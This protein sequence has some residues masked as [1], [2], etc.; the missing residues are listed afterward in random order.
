MENETLIVQ[1]PPAAN[2]AEQR[3]NPLQPPSSTTDDG[4]VT[5]EFRTAEELVAKAIAPVKR[6]YL[7]PPPSRSSNY[8]NTVGVENDDVAEAKSAPIIKDKKS[9]RQMKR[10][11]RQELKSPLHIC[12][13]VAKSGK[14]SACPYNDKCRFSHDVEAFK[15]EKPADI[16]GSCPFLI[17]EGPCPYGLACRFAGTHRDDVSA[18]TENLPVKSSE[19]NF[20]NKDTQ[21]LLWKNK[22]KFPETEATLKLLGLKGNPKD[23]TLGGKGE[24]GQVVPKEPATDTKTDNNEVANDSIIPFISPEDDADE[25]NLADDTRPL[26]K[27]KSSVNEI[28]SSQV[29]SGSSVQEGIL[30]SSCDVNKLEP[31]ADTVTDS[32]KSLKLHPRE[33]KLI[34][35]RD[36]LYLAPLTTVGNLPFR[37]VCKVL[38]ADVT[39]GEMAMCTN[40]LQ[41]Q[42]SEWALL[43]RHSSE[44]LFGV[45]IC[46]AY[47]DTVTKT[48]ELI[49]QECSVDFIDINMGCPIDIVVNKGAGSALLTK[50]MR[51]KSVVEAASLTVGTPVTIKVRTA[52]F[53]GKNRI[54]SLIADMGNWGATAVTIH[55][56]SRQQRYSKLADWDYIY[57]CVCKAPKSLQVLGNGDVFSY[58]DWN[59]HK[60][61]CPELS[62]CMIARGALVKPWI[63][64]EIKEQRHWDITS[65][66]RLAIL[67]DYARFGLEH[68]GSDSKGVETTR[69]FLLE[70]L[71]YTCRY[72]PVGLLDVIPQRINWRPPSYYG[73]DDL[74]TLMASDSAADWVRISEMLLG[75]VPSGFSFAPK[76]KSNAYDRAENG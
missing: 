51:M 5:Q 35:F 66:E 4:G 1:S 70:W 23:K 22:M 54:D 26:K 15:A 30:D 9:K 56:R 27:A 76:H 33:K 60:T 8:N 45:Q 39:C 62:T 14:V 10:E 42:A 21:K 34:D 16:E 55:G 72:V 58:V 43:R 19:L 74:E 75:K 24:N 71:S 52:Y 6:E 18:P 7:L 12:P 47:P 69:H 65:G 53:E 31:A 73:R 17:Y 11:R 3:E 37:R 63:F 36:K 32:D 67:K 29:S 50:P 41:G 57:Q 20:F 38:G 40:L 28:C 46:G 13:E 25:N 61:E 59:K 2:P 68:W 44:N 64:T 49:E 48:V